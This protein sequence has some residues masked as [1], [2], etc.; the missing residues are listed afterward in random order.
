MINKASW[1]PE[2]WIVIQLHRR[3]MQQ[4]KSQNSTRLSS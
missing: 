2:S 1:Y 4:K 3:D